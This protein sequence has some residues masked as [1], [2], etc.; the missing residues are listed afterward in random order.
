[1]EY[2]FKTFKKRFRIAT[3]K[4]AIDVIHELFEFTGSFSYWMRKI[5]IIQGQVFNNDPIWE[6]LFPDCILEDGKLILKFIYAGERLQLCKPTDSISSNWEIFIRRQLNDIKLEQYPEFI[7][8][9]SESPK[10][11]NKDEILNPCSFLIKFYR[12]REATQWA[13]RWNQFREHATFTFSIC[14]GDEGEYLEDFEYFLKLI[15]A[16]YLIHIA[17]KYK[18]N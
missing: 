3:E 2:N 14:E 12:K 10:H 11:L 13:K 18:G 9:L 4:E 5:K 1:M 7:K 6:K 16:I 17:Q 15:E 8:L